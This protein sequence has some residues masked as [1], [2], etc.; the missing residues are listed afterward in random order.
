[1]ITRNTNIIIIIL[2]R[3]RATTNVDYIYISKKI[4]NYIIPVITNSDLENN[5]C[6]DRTSTYRVTGVSR[7]DLE[8]KKYYSIA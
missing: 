8:E 3:F 2:I 1:M 6:H 4:W 7:G 5:T